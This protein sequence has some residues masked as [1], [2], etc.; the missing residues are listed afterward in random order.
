MDFPP[1]SASEKYLQGMYIITLLE[2]ILRLNV[3]N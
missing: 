3:E 2:G 1:N